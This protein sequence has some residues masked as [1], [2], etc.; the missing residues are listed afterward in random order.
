MVVDHF[1]RPSRQ[2]RHPE[3]SDRRESGDLI[4]RRHCK[5]PACAGMTAMD[6]METGAGM[7]LSGMA[8]AR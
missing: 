3:T 5:I 7:T 8:A 6:V 1:R 2:F 4:T